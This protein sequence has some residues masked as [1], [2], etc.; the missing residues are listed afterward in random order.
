MKKQD[1]VLQRLEQIIEPELAQLKSKMILEHDNRYHV[2]DQYVPESDLEALNG[3]AIEKK[4]YSKKKNKFEC[5]QTVLIY[6]MKMIDNL[7]LI[8]IPFI[9]K[10]NI[11]LIH[12]KFT[13]YCYILLQQI[14]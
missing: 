2:F 10:L 11:Y 3:S 9:L 13:Y 6:K 5:F 8:F 1:W 4:S 7:L 12:I 14:V